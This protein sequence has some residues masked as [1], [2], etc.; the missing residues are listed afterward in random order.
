MLLLQWC[1][2]YLPLV[3]TLLYSLLTP[4]SYRIIGCVAASTQ[5]LSMQRC[6]AQYIINPRHSCAGGL[7]YTCFV[8]LEKYFNQRLLYVSGRFARDLDY[9]FVA[10]Y[11][12][13]AKQI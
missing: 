2:Y 8:C 5:M 7:Q 1:L 9:L 6:C 4:L 12:V 13:E 10:Q 11:I 3:F